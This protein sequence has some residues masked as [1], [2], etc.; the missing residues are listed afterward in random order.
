MCVLCAPQTFFNFGL[1]PAILNQFA[2]PVHC[3]ARGSDRHRDRPNTLYGSEVVKEMN[4]KVGGAERGDLIYQLENSLY[5]LGE[6]ACQPFYNALRS[7]NLVFF[8]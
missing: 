1:S 8:R 7:V 4:E 6:D 5:V 3:Q 2:N